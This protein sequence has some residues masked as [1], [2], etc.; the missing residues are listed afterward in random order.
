MISALAAVAAAAL[1]A[2]APLHATV[3]AL[4]APAH[5]HDTR[6]G[7]PPTTV[8]PA[9]A[10]LRLDAAHRLATGRGVRVAVIDTGVAAHPRLTGRLTGGGDSVGG[11]T[12]M[13]D[14]DGHGTAVAGLIAAAPDDADAF[15]GVAPGASV[16]A[17]R[18]SSLVFLDDAGRT[19]PVGDTRT[20]ADAIDAAVRAGADVVNVSE[21]ACTS[22]AEAAAAAP[23]LRRALREAVEKNVVVVAAAG[24]IGSGG[25]TGELVALPGSL[26]ADVL[27]VGAVDRSGTPA[28]FSVRG[29]WI[30]VAAPGDGLASLA[31]PSGFTGPTVR[32]TSFAAPFVSGTAAL[33]RERNPR[34]S[35]RAIMDRIVSTARPAGPSDAV[36]AGIVDPVAALGGTADLA[37]RAPTAPLPGLGVR[38]APPPGLP[39]EVGAG[40][41]GVAALAVLLLVRALRRPRQR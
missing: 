36:G 15:T 1:L 25:C 10:A 14:C 17:I 7:P 11:G 12:G 3:P 2:V 21:A 23:P 13:Q 5:C 37:A 40:A 6:D 35:A 39:P 24:N 28:G 33:L 16:L 8:D 34:M 27:A 32:G 30:D 29:P 26:G 22:R 9:V 18:Q 19:T 20:L 4:H 31:I 41:V 38:M